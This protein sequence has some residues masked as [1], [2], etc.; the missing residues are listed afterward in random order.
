[1]CVSIVSLSNYQV[2]KFGFFGGEIMDCRHQKS[3]GGN[4]LFK[5]IMYLMPF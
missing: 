5:I 3:Q 1:M 2:S 4:F